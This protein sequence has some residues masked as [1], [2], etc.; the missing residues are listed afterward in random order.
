MKQS[1][2]KLHKTSTGFIHSGVSKRRGCN[3]VI[4]QYK[5]SEDEWRFSLPMDDLIFTKLEDIVE[6]LTIEGY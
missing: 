6:H 1:D 3:I 5:N 2:L 4:Y